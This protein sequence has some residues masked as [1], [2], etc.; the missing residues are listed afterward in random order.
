M[1]SGSSKTALVAEREGESAS[2][3]AGGVVRGMKAALGL[4]LFSSALFTYQ[5][6]EASFC[7]NHIETIPTVATIG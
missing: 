3:S 5:R 7:E 1:N 4:H 2:V 6:V